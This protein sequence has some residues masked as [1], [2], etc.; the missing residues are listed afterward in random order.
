M[1]FALVERNNR[2]ALRSKSE[3]LR[4]TIEF[5]QPAMLPRVWPRPAG[6]EVVEPRDRCGLV[7]KQVEPSIRTNF[8]ILRFRS[9]RLCLAVVPCLRAIFFMFA[10]S[11]GRG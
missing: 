11:W 8:Q 2:A 6:R 9:M 3:A 4:L 7:T 10:I 5:V 1:C